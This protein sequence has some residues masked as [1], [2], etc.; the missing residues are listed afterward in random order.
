[1]CVFVRVCYGPATGVGMR[2]RRLVCPDAS[3]WRDWDPASSTGQTECLS[4][5]A[6]EIHLVHMYVSILTSGPPF[7]QLERGAG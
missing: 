2:P 3:N 4:P 1:M 6:G 7:S 5:T